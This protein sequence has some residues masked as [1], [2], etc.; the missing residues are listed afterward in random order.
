[1]LKKAQSRISAVK[2]NTLYINKDMQHHWGKSTTDNLPL[3]NFP[4]SD[5]L[6]YLKQGT[7][8]SFITK[9]IKNVHS[10]S[11]WVNTSTLTILFYHS[12][13]T[14]YFYIIK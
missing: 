10:Q 8:A 5:G 1:M 12:L 2:E 14:F 13:E 4:Q 11:I 9:P 7:G 6:L 3:S